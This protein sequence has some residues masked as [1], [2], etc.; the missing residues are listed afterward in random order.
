[1]NKITV[2]SRGSRLALSQTHWVIGALKEKY[3]ECVFEVKIIKTKGDVILDKALDKIGDK[4]LFVTEIESA[5]LNGEIDFAVHSM[6][7]MPGENTAGLC[8]AMTPKREDPRDVLI[9]KENSNWTKLE[10]LPVGSVIGTGS[11]RRVAQLMAL[12]PDLTFVPVR[13]NVE[14]RIHKIETENLA[15][16]VLAAAGLHRLGLS[17]RIGCYLEAE[18]CLPAPAQGALGIQHRTTDAELAAMLRTIGCEKSHIHA[19]A[20][21]AFLKGISGSCHLPIGAFA[22]ETDQTLKLTGLYGD[23][24]CECI[25]KSALEASLPVSYKEAEQLGSQLAEAI[26][27]E[28]RKNRG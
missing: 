19:L 8:F 1:M 27:I 18:V 15:G 21:R 25:V 16:V 5:L 14:T 13:G 20:E 22:L 10:D 7:D 17:E 3:P 24:N 12:R 23:E 11:K 6:K 28:Y 4:G 26:M 2:G 9:F